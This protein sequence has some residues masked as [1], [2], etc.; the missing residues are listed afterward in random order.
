MATF[1][2][3]SV[4]S[5]RNVLKY[6][7]RASSH[8]MPGRPSSLEPPFTFMRPYPLTASRR[9]A[10]LHSYG[11]RGFSDRTCKPVMLTRASRHSS[12]PLFHAGTSSCCRAAGCQLG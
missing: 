2:A 1:G 4:A 5:V 10:P 11:F 9:P 6:G 7:V 3:L 8:A 12:L